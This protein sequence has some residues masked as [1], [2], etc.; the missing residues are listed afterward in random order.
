MFNEE[1]E[2]RVLVEVLQ[3]DARQDAANLYFIDIRGVRVLNREEEL[4]LARLVKQGDAKSKDLFIKHNLR[5]V[6]SV[7]KQYIR[8]CRSLAFSDLIQEGN[9]GL[10]TALEYFDPERGFKFSTYAVW[11]IRQAISRSIDEQ[12]SIIH[13][14]VEV[15]RLKKQLFYEGERFVLQ[16][17]RA[18]TEVEMSA[19]LGVT[20]ARLAEL[21]FSGNVN[22]SIDAGCGDGDDS[23]LHHLIV[24]EHAA[25]PDE[26]I[27]RSSRRKALQKFLSTVLDPKE[28]EIIELLFGF[29]ESE[30][31][32]DL[33]SIAKKLG[34]TRERA[35]QTHR[36]A[37]RKLQYAAWKEE[38]LA[39]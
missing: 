6:V 38:D 26:L 35:N 29:D 7:A 21:H 3:R 31:E 8:K 9:C 17:G 22:T 1:N 32:L 23:N 37:L 5:L 15:A 13:L 30:G 10:L 39:F 4:D 20:C 18:P 11:W 16:Y 14:P 19:I 12:D 24:D 36:Q 27:E 2:V 28:K 25:M 34:I 33:A